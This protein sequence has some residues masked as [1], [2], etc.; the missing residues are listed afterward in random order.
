MTEK[1][2]SYNVDA[3]EFPDPELLDYSN[4]ALH[5]LIQ[6]K[7]PLARDHVDGLG[8]M[9]HQLQID[10]AQDQID[11]AR[12][13]LIDRGETFSK[14][15]QESLPFLSWPLSVQEKA[16]KEAQLKRQLAANAAAAAR[17]EVVLNKA[18]ETA[19]A[20]MAGGLEND[21]ESVRGI[22]LVI[23]RSGWTR[24]QGVETPQG[25]SG[26]EVKEMIAR[27][28]ALGATSA[29]LGGWTCSRVGVSFDD[30]PELSFRVRME[31]PRHSAVWAFLREW[32][33]EY[34]TLRWSTPIIEV[35]W[36]NEGERA[37]SWVT[38]GEL[39]DAMEPKPVDPLLNLL[40]TL[41]DV[42]ESVDTIITESNER[43]E[44]KKLMKLWSQCQWVPYARTIGVFFLIFGLLRLTMIGL[45]STPGWV[46]TIFGAVVLIA[47]EYFVLL[48]TRYL[49]QM[50]EARRAGSN[51]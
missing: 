50:D 25:P 7:L 40:D 44:S 9:H 43:A 15:E 31:L 12:D 37:C 38:L 8:G 2:S 30:D 27:L 13:I 20:A 5:K 6:S 14:E 39:W 49:D 48:V 22:T 11:Q 51:R 28:H 46:M 24:I 16:E 23:S 1:E 33:N 41:M 17:R 18:L 21:V 47:T 10:H 26:S 35:D 36:L 32:H 34:E 42:P 19:K 45:S 4:E 3:Y 29:N